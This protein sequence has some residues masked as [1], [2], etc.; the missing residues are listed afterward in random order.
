MLTKLSIT[1]ASVYPVVLV[2]GVLGNSLV[3]ATIW[4]TP[5]LRSS[6]Y[7]FTASLAAADLLVMLF[8]L[9]ANFIGM[10]HRDW[11]VVCFVS[12]NYLH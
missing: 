7:I 11:W 8:C 3:L 6:T 12:L 9:P 1:I 2:A 5:K 10:L 4:N